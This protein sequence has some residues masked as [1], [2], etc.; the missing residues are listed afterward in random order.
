[1]M[2]G[3]AFSYHAHATSQTIFP[4]LL[5]LQLSI[6]L[7]FIF[8]KFLRSFQYRWVSGMLIFACWAV[9]G[10]VRTAMQTNYSLPKTMSEESLTY[11]GIVSEEP[12][13]GKNSFKVPVDLQTVLAAGSLHSAHEKV[14]LYLPPSQAAEAL[15]Y[16]DRLIFNTSLQVVKPGGNPG[17]FDYAAFL[18]RDGIYRTAFVGN[19]KFV[20]IDGFAGNRL[21]RFAS[22]VGQ[23]LLDTYR[24]FGLTG[25][26]LAIVSALTLG[27]KEDLSEPTR[28]TFSESGAM[29]I[30][31]VSGLHVGIIQ[32]ILN[33][34]LVFLDKNKKLKI[35]KAF[36]I[37]LI[38]WFYAFITG[39]SPSVTRAAIM[40]SLI[41]IGISFRQDISIF[42]IVAFSALVVLMYNP[43]LLFD[44][45]FQYSYLALAGILF[46]HPKIY[47]LVKSK[48]WIVD[49]TWALLVA[50]FSAQLSLAP[51]SIFYF[52]QFPNYFLLT[53]LLAI[54]FA[55]II[56]MLAVGL[57]AFSFA[58]FIASVLA[59]VL[60]KVVWFLIKGLVLIQNLP[61]S[62]SNGIHLD[63]FSLLLWY[64][65]IGAISIYFIRINKKALIVALSLVAIILS[66]GLVNQY[67][68]HDSVR[69]TVFNLSKSTAIFGRSGQNSFLLCDSS[70]YNSEES[71]AFFFDR[72]LSAEGGAKTQ[73]IN[74]DSLPNENQVSMELYCRPGFLSFDTLK[75]AIVSD[76]FFT[77]KSSQERLEVDYVLLRNNPSIEI[78]KLIDCFHFDELIV[79]GSNAFWQIKKWQ[80]ECDGLGVNYFITHAN[81]A[82]DMRMEL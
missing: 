76:D 61:G 23:K 51:L 66:L 68:R 64:L 11:T 78:Q 42:N 31:A 65:V 35:A 81:G 37:I 40:F 57:F 5:V 14:M 7:L 36:I 2:A 43:L 19:G 60:Q 62:V 49:K 47:P 21:I 32:L 13:R 52:G 79:D 3:I 16:G 50:S 39:L 54:P 10:F 9:T 58:E 70:L 12:A 29:H 77:N 46:F 38:L 15:H 75:M 8:G 25:Q 20:Q 82:K 33:F 17:E 63:Q 6:A 45:G 69:F 26:E 71:R 67:N 41:Q 72:F 55:F 24:K 1:M 59:F 56:L 27:Y 44:I 28:K 74:L 53:N 48:Y 4:A 30:L 73:L 22:D 18:K 80:N 34:L